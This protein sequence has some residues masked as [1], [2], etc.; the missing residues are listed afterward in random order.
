MASYADQVDLVYVYQMSEN[1]SNLVS[2]RCKNAQFYADV[3]TENF[4]LSTLTVLSLRLEKITIFFKDQ[5][6]AGESAAT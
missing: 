3:F 2:S 6:E 5:I 4:L 1:D